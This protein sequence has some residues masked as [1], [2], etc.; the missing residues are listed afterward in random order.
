M[1]PSYNALSTLFLAT[2]PFRPQT[3]TVVARRMLTGALGKNFK[4]PEE[5]EKRER[6]NLKEA[7]EQKR[8]ASNNS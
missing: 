4:M 2:L 6:Q 8:L 5:Q 3:S 7:K 1:L